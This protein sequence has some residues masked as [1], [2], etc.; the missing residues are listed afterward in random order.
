MV[1]TAFIVIRSPQELDPVETMHRLADR[2]DST[3]IL[4]ED[5]VYNAL[6][7]KR[8]ALIAN[9]AADVIV[10]HDDLEARGF[11]ESD[12]KVGKAADYDQIIETIMERT[13]RTVTI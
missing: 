13:E 8:S 4:F 7:P 11:R 6:Q 2:D 10:A 9:A 5:G 12:L 1:R 3:A